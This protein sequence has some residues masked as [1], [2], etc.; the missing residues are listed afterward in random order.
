MRV[1]IV[2]GGGR[3]HALA[4]AISRSPGVEMVAASPGNPGTEVLG[5]RVSGAV[6]A[7]WV[8]I[9]TE[10]RIDLAVIGPEGPLV[11]GAA[12]AL[13]AAGV[14][15]F[16]PSAEA[17]RLEASKVFAKQFMLRHGIPTAEFQ[18]FSSADDAKAFVRTRSKPMVVKADGLAGGKGVLVPSTVA[19]TMVAID[20]VLTERDFGDAGGRIVLEERLIGPE[21][22]VMAIVDGKRWFLLP[23]SRDHKRLED[24]DRGPNTGGM[25][26]IAPLS[27]LD[28]QLVAE[29]E[30]R[31][32]APTVAG[33]RA[34]G[35]P[36]V[37]CLYAGLMLTSTGPRVLEFNVRFGDPETQALLPLLSGDVAG[38]LLSAARGA[39]APECA[40]VENRVA[41]TVVLAA[42]GYPRAPQTGQLITGLDSL[43]P[44]CLAFHAGTARDSSGRIVVAGGRVV[45]L[46]GIGSS[47]ATAIAR[48]YTAIEQVHFPGMHYRR[49]IGSNTKDNE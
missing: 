15:V 29:V 18:V 20:R 46:T 43:P 22:S 41:A 47:T 4:W 44:D 49:D 13:R 11:A 34:E 6:P 45:A 1:L 30:Q 37:G 17:S 32:I 7:E 39:L 5:P 35:M 31:V 33:L 3:E 27:G 12:D 23:L 8:R 24:G 38:L 19:E 14:A 36:F 26:A 48:A 42:P 10:L 40:R 21:V 16:G 9:A 28:P 2:G 25:G